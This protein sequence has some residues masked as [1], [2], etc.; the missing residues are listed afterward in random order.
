MI[1]SARCPSDSWAT[2]GKKR[3]L[4]LIKINC[5]KFTYSPPDFFSPFTTIY[6]E[7]PKVLDWMRLLSLVSMSL[8][9]LPLLCAKSCPVFQRL[10][11][12]LS[13]PDI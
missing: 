9:L 13:K 5:K 10:L 1:Y 3:R 7:M 2:Q 11:I 4:R 12:Q 6:Y 8:Y